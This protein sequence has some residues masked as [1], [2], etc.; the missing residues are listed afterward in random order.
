MLR[1]SVED[2]QAACELAQ[3]SSNM[4]DRMLTDSQRGASWLRR[5][6]QRE[7]K[8]AEVE[9]PGSLWGS[10]P[11]TQNPVPRWVHLSAFVIHTIGVCNNA[12]PMTCSIVH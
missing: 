11:M 5:E 8:Y 3:D 6:V 12:G 9:G 2:V 10:T 7:L 4:V 1:N